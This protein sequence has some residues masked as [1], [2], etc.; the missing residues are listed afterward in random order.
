MADALIP[1]KPALEGLESKWDAAWTQRAR[2]CSTGS[3][4]PSSAAPASSRS[5]LPRRP[6]REAFTSATSSATRTPT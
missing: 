1:D 3:A 2:T 4:P 5:T 6:R